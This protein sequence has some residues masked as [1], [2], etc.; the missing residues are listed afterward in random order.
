MPYRL[1]HQAA[2]NKLPGARRQDWLLR[3]GPYASVLLGLSA[4]LLIWVGALYFSYTEKQ[5]TERAA[6]QNAENLSRAFEE[7]IIRAIRA[8]DQTLLYVRDSYARDMDSFDMS[9]WTRSSQFLSDFTFQVVVIGKDGLMV[10]SNIPGSKPGL[11][12]SDRE[13][14]K[15]H[16]ARQV[17]ELF[18]SKPIFGR[19]SGKWSIQLT[20]RIMMPD[21]SFGGVVVVSLDPDYLAKFYQSIDVGK[22]GAVTL[23]GLDGIVRARGSAGAAAI[24]QSLAGGALFR[25][26]SEARS[27]SYRAVSQLD[28]IERLVAYRGVKG[29]PLIV[30]VGLSV[31]E[32]LQAHKQGFWTKIAIALMLTFWILGMMFFMSRYQRILSHARDAA[33]AGTRARS[34]FLAMMSHEI[35]TP[36]NGVV[37]MSEVLLATELTPEQFGCAKTLRESATHLLQVIND[38]LDFSKLEADRVE[39]ERIAFDPRKLV[40][41]SVALLA[42]Q[43][44]EKGLELSALFTDAVPA[45]VIGDPAHLR[46]VLF[47]LVGNGLKFT[48]QGRVTVNVDVA[49]SS[50]PDRIRLAFEVCDTG[51]GIPRDGIALLFREF[52]QLD[53]SIARR[54][55]GTGLGL[56]ISRR[57]VGLMGGT[58]SV[59]SEAGKG[60]TFKF[61]IEC[62]RGAPSLVPPIGSDDGWASAAP[63]Q[64]TAAGG[65]GVR[66]LLVEDNKTNQLVA[67]KILASL[68]YAVD[69]AGNGVEAV[70][71]CTR[72]AYDLVFMDVMMP[73]MDGLTAARA[74]RQLAGAHGTPHIVALTA[75]VQ[76]H[77]RDEC[78]NAGMNDFVPKPLTRQGLAEAIARFRDTRLCCAP[79]EMADGA[80]PSDAACRPRFESGIYSEL[81]EV[82]GAADSKMVMQTFL[83]DTEQ[84]IVSMRASA[85]QGDGAAVQ[86]DAHATKSTAASLGFLRLSDIARE[87]EQDALGLKGQALGARL[88]QLDQSFAEIR[89]IAVA[90]I[91]LVPDTPLVAAVEVC[92]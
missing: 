26:F 64:T 8:A 65:A 50:D 56:A 16:A 91:E 30:S 61:S 42:T 76:K 33:E 71:A 87:L 88:D 38:V 92:V 59:E 72:T 22:L 10:A 62:L 54:F 23:V 83:V 63:G 32:V 79:L 13:H 48:K 44:R 20:R 43:A 36:M 69:I 18:I 49:A 12:L 58:I 68:G 85:E 24:G 37:G 39:I 84:R 40:E 70:A 74:V 55:G 25:Q 7:Q 27:G 86:R 77:D 5:Q 34:E 82:L 73:E 41:D 67:T 51:I 28:R 15:V 66:G 11:D 14:F 2:L 45:S 4:V 3:I 78:L 75:N 1:V 89:P 46:Q 31:N 21:G 19:V 35:R 90:K 17:D 60:S 47:N 53:S 9:L 29:Y 81:S 52:S 6:I 80:E 57:L